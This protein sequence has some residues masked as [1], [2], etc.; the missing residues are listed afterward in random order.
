MQLSDAYPL[1]SNVI[2]ML[3]VQ[4]C[5]L[6]YTEGNRYIRLYYI[7]YPEICEILK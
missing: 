3:N 6:T 1:P 2:L 4:F 7:S 5:L